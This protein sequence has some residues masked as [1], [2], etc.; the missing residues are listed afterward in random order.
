MSIINALLLGILQGFTEFL[1]ISSSGHLVI[2]QHLLGFKDAPVF[3]DVLL[4]GGSL[5]AI[6]IFFWPQIKN[7][8]VNLGKLIIFGTIPAVFAG[9]LID[10]LL[11]QIFSSLPLV[12]IG[13]LITS[14][15]LATTLKFKH[16]SADLS[17]LTLK[18][19]IIIGLFQAAAIIP[20]ISRSGSTVVAGLSQGLKKEDA[21]TFS[22]LLAIPA[23]AGALVLELKDLNSLHITDPL[24]YLFGFAASLICSLLALK[25]LKLIINQSKLHY[26]AVYCFLLSAGL[27]TYL[28]FT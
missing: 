15:L 7:I 3:F 24:S 17:Q 4:H 26:F 27:F 6:L 13:L 22:F 23:I 9:L 18:Q 12:A 25:L 1:P 21:F 8:S 16:T 5:A 14:V 10:P 28:V 2:A 11:G 20:G 19:V